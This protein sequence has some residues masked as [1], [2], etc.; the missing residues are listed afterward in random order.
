MGDRGERARPAAAV[1]GAVGG[2]AGGARHR[3]PDLLQGHPAGRGHGRRRAA[4]H[5]GGRGVR[6]DHRRDHAAAGR[7]PPARAPCRGWAPRPRRSPRPAW[8][9]SPPA[10]TTT[11]CSSRG[12][13]DTAIGVASAC[14]ST[15]SCGR[16]CAGVRPPRRSTASTTASASCWSTWPTAWRTGARTRTSPHGSTAPVT[17]T[18]TSTRPGR[19]CA[20]PQESARMNPRRSARL[21]KNPQQWHESAAPHG[22][23][24][25]RDAQPRPHARRASRPTGR[26]GARSSRSRGSRCSATR[27]GRPAHADPGS[28]ARRTPPARGAQR[29]AASTERSPEWPIYGA[30]IINLR[31]IVDA[32]D[33][34]PRPTRSAARALPCQP[35]APTACRVR[36]LSPPHGSSPWPH[37]CSQGLD[38]L[39]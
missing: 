2:P 27:A 15:C 33:G 30:L 9:S 14:S 22:A 25:R 28:A 37:L 13:Y 34:S 31:N 11:S 17:S 29:G 23:G 10:S 19:W 4:R 18:E 24:R 21:M 3:L 26:R 36:G 7:R 32:M 12:C 5:G 8:W 20:R 38:Q 16:R 35:A 6:A 1:P 39:G